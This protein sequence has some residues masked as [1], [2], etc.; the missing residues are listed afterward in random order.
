MLMKRS[1]TRKIHLPVISGREGDIIIT[2]WI[3]REGDSVRMGDDLVEVST[4]KA[5]FD[6]PSP[7]EGRIVSIR[8]REGEA[9]RTGDII[10][11]II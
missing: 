10:A 1:D 5:T 3:V 2:R 7:A 6:V 9:A 11:E 4:D 8:K